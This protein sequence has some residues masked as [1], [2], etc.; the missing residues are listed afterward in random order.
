MDELQK[1]YKGY[2]VLQYL[3]IDGEFQGAVLGHWRIGPYDIED[4]LL[5]LPS[6]QVEFRKKEIIG[7]VREIY[8]PDRH[9][10]LKYHGIPQ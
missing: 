9:A 5:E 2:E 8:S 1:R 6:D 4:I 3:L 10:I 7:A